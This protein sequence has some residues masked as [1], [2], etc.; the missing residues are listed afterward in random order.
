MDV[1]PVERDMRSRRR[2]LPR[3]PPSGGTTKHSVSQSLLTPSQ[4]T[5]YYSWTSATT[6]EDVYNTWFYFGQ[7]NALGDTSVQAVLSPPTYQP[8]PGPVPAPV[9]PTGRH[10]YDAG[11]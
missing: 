7:W 10:E 3:C 5:T 11:L 2:K 1:A 8:P 4:A 9:P 6:N